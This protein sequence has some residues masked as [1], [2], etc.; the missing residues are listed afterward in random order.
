MKNSKI[1]DSGFTDWSPNLLPD[2]TGKIY[3]ITGGNSGIG[4][5]AAKMLAK[6]NAD[7]VIGCR[8]PEKAKQAVAEIN[9]PGSGN[10]SSVSL[11]LSSLTSVRTASAEIHARYDKFDGLIN[12]AGIMQP[13][14]TTTVDGF[15]LQLATNHLEHFLL[16]SLL[17]DLVEKAAGRIVVISSIAHKFGRIDFDDLMQ[18]K[19]Y[20]SGKAHGQSKLANLMFALEL[21]RKL[22]AS[23]SSVSCIACHPGVSATELFKVKGLKK[24]VEYK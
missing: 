16:T 12:N 24:V 22:K 13:P 9:M 8:S 20:N 14:Q 3:L 19:T 5:E 2:L 4:L 10:T 17:F 6:A 1:F 21:D 15:E 23:G 18:A 11:D 7:I